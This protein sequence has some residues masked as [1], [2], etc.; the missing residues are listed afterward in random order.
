[1]DLNYKMASDNNNNNNNNNNSNTTTNNNNINNNYN[2][3]DKEYMS[4]IDFNNE[5]IGPKYHNLCGK[6]NKSKGT[7]TCIQCMNYYSV[8]GNDQKNKHSTSKSHIQHEDEYKNMKIKLNELNDN[9]FSLTAFEKSV[10][11]NDNNNYSSDRKIIERELLSVYAST[12]TKLNLLLHINNF[13]NYHIIDSIIPDNNSI[14][15]AISN[16]IYDRKE[17]QFY[18]I[19]MK[20]KNLIDSLILDQLSKHNKLTNTDKINIIK[21]TSKSSSINLMD[22]IEKTSKNSIANNKIKETYFFKDTNIIN[23]ELLFSHWDINQQ[24]PPVIIID[25]KITELQL[26]QNYDYRNT[27]IELHK[28][29]SFYHESMDTL[30]SNQEYWGNKWLTLEFMKKILPLIEAAVNCPITLLSSNELNGNIDRI[31]KIECNNDDRR[32]LFPSQSKQLCILIFYCESSDN[33]P[34]RPL[35]EFDF[36]AKELVSDKTYYTIEEE[37]VIVRVNEIEEEREKQKEGKKE[38]GKEEEGTPSSSCVKAQKVEKYEYNLKK[39]NIGYMEN[40]NESF[41][42]NSNLKNSESNR[43]FRIYP[44]QNDI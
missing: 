12:I 4:I 9:S 35:K 11:I 44:I 16:L 22:A 21:K 5:I 3:N 32:I 13:Q 34:Y 28:E 10:S 1:M 18:K 42:L 41:N 8:I 36:S 15:R 38:G 29:V 31:I 26:P 30:V 33:Q 40:L 7:F 24:T 37:Q 23:Y 43:F 6:N 39:N 2:N 20:L 25:G 17:K 27:V 14:F 19:K